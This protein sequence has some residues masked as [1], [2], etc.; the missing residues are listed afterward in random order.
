LTIVSPVRLY[1][2]KR[3][4]FIGHAFHGKTKSSHFFKRLLWEIG[5]VEELADDALDN[6]ELRRDYRELVEGQNYH[7]VVVWQIEYVAQQLAGLPNVVFVPM[8]DGCR[9]LPDQFWRSLL[10]T[11]VLSFSL[12]VFEK[13]QNAGLETIYAQYWPALPDFEL[14]AV[15]PNSAF[16][17]YRRNDITLARLENFCQE[18]GIEELTILWQPD[19][20]VKR[21]IAKAEFTSKLSA[22]VRFVPWHK[23][24]VAQLSEI[25]STEYYIAS[26]LYEGI[27][28]SFLEAMALGCCV[29]APKNPTYTDYIVSGANGLLY[30]HSPRAGT[31]PVKEMR[32]NAY[33]SFAAGRDRWERCVPGIL[34]WLDAREPFDFFSVPL[35]SIVPNGRG[36]KPLVTVVT[37][38]RNA[39]ADLRKTADSVLS[40][41]GVNFEYIVVDGAST[42]NTVTVASGY[43]RR[44]DRVISEPDRGA[45][46]AMNKGAAVASGK[47][48]MF[49]NA[50]DVFLNEGSLAEFVGSA[51]DESDFVIGHHVYKADQM[52]EPRRV[53]DFHATYANLVS[54]NISWEW[55]SGIPSHQSTATR[56]ELL[57]NLKYDIAFDIAADHDLM[58]RAAAQGAKFTVSNVYV[59]RYHRGGISSRRE[60]DCFRQ[61][62]AIAMKHCQKR[63]S[64]DALYAKSIHSLLLHGIRQADS[65]KKIASLFRSE[66][67]LLIRE[68]TGRR[69]VRYAARKLKKKLLALRGAFLGSVDFRNSGIRSGVSLKGFS[70]PED[71][72]SWIDWPTAEVSFDAPVAGVNRIRV[73]VVRSV[74]YIR[75]NDVRIKINGGAALAASLS[76]GAND[77]LLPEPV[78][79]RS[80]RLEIAATPSPKDL[81]LG[82]DDRHISFLISHIQLFR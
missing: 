13:A 73:N 67:R 79:L 35:D 33:R 2:P 23:D 8:W 14:P 34:A 30:D 42:D 77:I 70:Y 40:Q 48:V 41:Q 26:R 4:L 64:V 76:T 54:G 10:G 80:V 27:G 37:V 11:R 18:L 22:N 39:A 75:T 21:P 56:T 6:P 3:I 9:E 60:F 45:Y 28:M 47:Y 38:V 66:P 20:P 81:G 46:D 12:P 32:K 24:K 74:D 61:W 7:L 71:P 65:A 49:M 19:P 82:D 5:S 51:E 69:V 29:V 17:W 44:I 68:I 36:E 55:H 31:L 58:F 57:R 53:S 1:E 50:G 59:S 16:Y 15:R 62:N 52:Q 78:D 25:A 63:A 43:G 72:G